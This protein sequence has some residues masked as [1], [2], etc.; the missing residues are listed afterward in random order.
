MME[1]NKCIQFTKGPWVP[2]RGMEGQPNQF[3]PD[4]FGRCPFSQCVALKVL[5]DPNLLKKL[6]LK[7]IKK[8]LK[9]MVNGFL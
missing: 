9:K 5:S 6:F 8:N 7:R 1:N 3:F 4:K 2:C